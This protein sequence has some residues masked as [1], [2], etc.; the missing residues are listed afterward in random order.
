MLIR[1]A[2]V[3]FQDLQADV[4]AVGVIDCGTDILMRLQT[5][6]AVVE[7]IG[8]TVFIIQRLSEVRFTQSIQRRSSL[9][10]I[11]E[12]VGIHIGI[13]IVHTKG[14][15]RIHAKAVLQDVVCHLIHGSLGNETVLTAEIDQ[16]ADIA[17][18]TAKVTG[19]N[20]SNIGDIQRTKQM[21]EVCAL[22]IG[23]GE[24]SQI[25][26]VHGSS[27]V[28]CILLLD[29]LRESSDLLSCQSDPVAVIITIDT[30]SQEVDHQQVGVIVGTAASGKFIGIALQDLQ[31][32]QKLCITRDTVRRGVFLRRKSHHRKHADDHC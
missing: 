9:E 29:I 32:G 3:S 21:A 20:R 25:P 16:I 13:E 6:K 7:E 28:G 26:Q 4:G 5:S 10:L 14:I 23:G 11:V 12:I 15:F 22:T 24:S 30:G 18:P 17:C 1:Q 31:I 2:A 19:G 8:R 27:A